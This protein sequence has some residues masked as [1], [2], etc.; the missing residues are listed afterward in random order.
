MNAQHSDILLLWSRTFS[1]PSSLWSVCIHST[2]LV[3]NHLCEGLDIL[4]FILKGSRAG[5]MAH[6]V[7]VGMW[8]IERM[9]WE[10]FKSTGACNQKRQQSYSNPLGFLSLRHAGSPTF[11]CTLNCEEFS[12][13]HPRWG[14]NKTPLK[15]W[16]KWTTFLYKLSLLTQNQEVGRKQY[17]SH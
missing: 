17:L 3:P 11:S 4:K 7:T 13:E 1:V 5:S 14:W 6:S 9:E 8:K 2:L 15:L 16:A 10:V 12:Q